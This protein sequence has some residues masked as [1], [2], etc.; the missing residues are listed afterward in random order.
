MAGPSNFVTGKK[1]LV[2]NN[3]DGSKKT[4]GS[5]KN[6][7]KLDKSSNVDESEDN[8]IECRGCK[9]KVSSIRLHLRKKSC[10]QQ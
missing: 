7:S 6:T 10:K 2:Q 5:N 3:S 9:K 1:T 8:L 4:I